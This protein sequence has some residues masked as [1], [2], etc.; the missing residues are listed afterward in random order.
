MNISRRIDAARN[1]HTE[2]DN[3]LVGLTRA[4]A[5]AYIDA[6]IVN[7]IGSLRGGF[8]VVARLLIHI[9]KRVEALE[10]LAELLRER[11]TP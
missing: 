6:N 11:R 9:L 2:D 7:N 8:K 5:E 1:K 10:E 3:P 4:Q